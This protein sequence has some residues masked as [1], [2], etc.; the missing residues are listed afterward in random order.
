[1]GYPDLRTAICTL[2]AMALLSGGLQA[3][4]VEFNPEISVQGEYTD[5]VTVAPGDTGETDLISRV[6]VLLPVVRRWDSGQLEFRYAPSYD[7]YRDTSYLDSDNQDLS[8]AVRNGVSRKAR[9]TLDAGYNKSVQQGG[10]DS[11]LS[12]DL[13]LTE[14]VDREQAVF[15]ASFQRDFSRR[16]SWTGA[17]QAA[18]L[19]YDTLP[20]GGP[21]AAPDIVDRSEWGA[22]LAFDHALSAKATLGVEL[23]RSS[24]EL[25]VTGSEDVDQVSAV[26]TRT[27][28]QPGDR[29]R[30]AVGVADRSGDFLPAGAMATVLVDETE[31][32]VDASL[33]KTLRRSSWTLN[34]SRAPS[35]GGSSVVVTTD[36]LA[37]IV[38]RFT[39]GP[40]WSGSVSGRYVSRDPVGDDIDS[41]DSAAVAAAVEWRPTRNVGYRFGADYSDQSGQF[42]M[43]DTTVAR[44]WFGLV[45]YPRGP[46]GDSGGGS[47]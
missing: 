4:D 3:A 16:W 25:D 27:L 2:S 43:E 1:M 37:G 7:W 24:N 11:L 20:G 17:I 41:I 10:A 36:T 28:S 40:Y 9:F 12:G 21:G 35:S 22:S 34:A 45:W 38:Y 31:L 19:R 26:W 23:S 46:M 42:D 47:R 30:L 6:R 18:E 8:F 29:F 13:I 32:A 14:P 39:P 44:G 5:N 33:T 15:S